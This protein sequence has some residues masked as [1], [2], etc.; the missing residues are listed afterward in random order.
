MTPTPPNST[1]RA[2][3]MLVIGIL[4]VS[5]AAVFIRLAQEESVP[6]LVIAGGRLLFAT[7]LLIP[8]IMQRAD[9]RAQIRKIS[10]NDAIL[11]FISGIFL[12]L[13]FITWISS[14]EYTSVLISG[15]LVTT[16][17]IWVAI[18]EV[19]VLKSRLS[20]GVI[21]GLGMALIGGIII[22]TPSGGIITP[23][24]ADNPILGG[25]LA[26]LGAMAVAVYLIIGRKMRGTI[27]LTPYIFM[28]YGVG[29]MTTLLVILISNTPFLGLSSAGYGWVILVAVMPQLIGH[30]S[31]NYALAYLPATIVSLSTQTEPIFSALGA[32]LVFGELPSWTQGLGGAIILIGVVSATISNAN[33]SKRMAT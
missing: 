6:S 17:P 7:V 11:I 13:H 18:L 23:P 2:L 29:A 15:V 10:R 19:V 9:Y 4:A 26:L 28:V 20:W 32:F 33:N 8:I 3:M 5:L 21:L 27:A 24:T 25:L 30:T 22:A 16:S 14:L 12:A 31:L 1:I